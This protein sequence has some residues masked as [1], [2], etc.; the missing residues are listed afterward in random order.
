MQAQVEHCGVAIDTESWCLA[1]S[2]LPHR[3][4]AVRAGAAR[5]A[6]ARLTGHGSCSPVDTWRGGLAG[7]TPPQ[8]LTRTGLD[9]HA[10][11]SW[12]GAHLHECPTIST[13]ARGRSP[14]AIARHIVPCTTQS[15]AALVNWVVTLVILCWLEGCQAWRSVCSKW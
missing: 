6:P 8:V 4:Q 9:I 1:G 11:H 5:T 13:G 3:A 14:R 2:T 15:K 10:G 12:R 7:N